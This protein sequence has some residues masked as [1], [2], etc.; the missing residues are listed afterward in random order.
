MHCCTSTMTTKPFRLPVRMPVRMPVR[1][2]LADSSAA[3][4]K[5][6]KHVQN[7]IRSLRVCIDKDLAVASQTRHDDDDRFVRQVCIDTWGRISSNALHIQYLLVSLE[8]EAHSGIQRNQ[9]HTE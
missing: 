9:G 7:K 8:D 5:R 1:C 2:D 4:Q 6:A 3:H